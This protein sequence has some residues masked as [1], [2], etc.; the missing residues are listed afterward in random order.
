MELST[1]D[2]GAA[3]ALYRR[4][5]KRQ[6]EAGG[7]AVLA[8]AWL[9]MERERGCAEELFEAELRVEPVLVEAAAAAEAAANAQAAATAQART[10]GMY[11]A[12]LGPGCRHS[13]SGGPLRSKSLGWATAIAH[14][15][16]CCRWAG[17][18]VGAGACPCSLQ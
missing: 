3:R 9:R 6:L 1:G 2:V 10:R 4:C 7:G 5:V 15:C 12:S 13:A 18:Y 8:E 16:N 17:S 11:R 14:G